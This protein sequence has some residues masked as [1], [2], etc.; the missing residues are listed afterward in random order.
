MSFRAL[1]Q[2]T[3]TLAPGPG[4]DR[5]VDGKSCL[6]ADLLPRGAP[7]APKGRKIVRNA[8]TNLEERGLST[9]F[10]ALDLFTWTDAGGRETQSPLALLPV[11]G[12]EKDAAGR[13]LTLE[14]TDDLRINPILLQALTQDHGIAD[15]FPDG[16]DSGTERLARLRALADRLATSI[17]RAKRTEAA[18]LDNFSFQKMAMVAELRAHGSD[19]A[20]H[21]LIAA[22]ARDPGAEA[23]MSR[24]EL[25]VDPRTFDDRDPDDEL[26]VLDADS[27][28]LRVIE[29]AVR[30]RSGVIFGAPGTGKSQT[31]ANLVAAMVGSG[32]RVLFVAEKRAALEVVKRRLTSAGLDHLVLDLHG[33]DVSRRKLA[34][35][36]ESALEVVRSTPPVDAKAVH[37]RFVESRHTL[38]GRM[39]RLH[40]RRAEVDHSV[41]DILGTLLRADVVPRTRWRG[42]ELRALDSD[43]AKRARQLLEH[44]VSYSEIVGATS[45]SRWMRATAVHGETILRT[46]DALENV[47]RNTAPRLQVQ[48]ERLRTLGFAGRCLDDM[49]LALETERSLAKAISTWNRRLLEIDLDVAERSLAPA[50]GGFLRR[51]LAFLFSSAFRAALR[52]VRAARVTA[53]VAR[54]ALESVRA[55]RPLISRW[56]SMIP[57]ADPFDAASECSVLEATT[58]EATKELGAIARVLPERFG[59]LDPRE[60][61]DLAN[62]YLNEEAVARRLVE[63]RR[64]RACLDELAVGRLVD[65]LSRE[66]VH[67]SGWSSAFRLAWLR[68]ALDDVLTREPDLVNDGHLSLDEV[69]LEFRRS[70]EARLKLASARVRRAH[71]FRYADVCN[72]VP[73]QHRTLER[74]ARKRARHL[75]F[76]TLL[77]QAGTAVT[78][79]CPCVMASPLSVSQLLPPNPEL[80]DLV[81]FD[82]ASQVMPAD[83]VCALLRAKCAVVAGDPKQLP[84]TTFFASSEEVEDSAFEGFESLIDALLPLLPAWKLEWHY[85]SRDER[86]I[87]FSNHHIYANG[88]VTFPGARQDAPVSFEE[89]AFEPREGIEDSGPD[90]VKTVV[91]RVIEHAKK[92]PELSLGVITMGIKHAERVLFALDRALEAESGLDEFFDPGR[93][94]R[95]FVKNLEQVQGDER[96]VVFLSVGYSKGVDGRLR[97]NFGPLTQKGGARRLN[98]AIT[99]ARHEMKVF[100]SFSHRDVDPSRT[101]NE[102]IGLLARFLEYAES[103]GR[104]L[105]GPGGATAPLNAFEEDVRL[106]LETSG[107]SVVPQ[108]GV[109][110]YRIDFAVQ[111]PEQPGRFVLAIE[112]DGA[113]YHAAAT[114]RDR[115]RLRQRQLEALGWRVHRIWSSDWFRDRPAELARTLAVIENAIATAQYAPPPR[116]SSIPAPPKPAERSRGPRPPQPT[117]FSS[118]EQLPGAVLIGYVEWVRS[119]G[120]VRFDEDVIEEVAKELGFKRLGTRIRARIAAALDEVKTRETRDV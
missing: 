110:K 15:S 62:G 49:S 98:V 53:T 77:E 72:S 34:Q 46:L 68:S 5:L 103:G 48:L 19:F 63:G 79:L 41:Y 97:Y 59:A 95:F 25:P 45:T 106:A 13:K 112:C 99:R 58:V 81:I 37:E 14:A 100:A 30:G 119:D 21:D 61:A 115:D 67:A 24:R 20:A 11:E 73:D 114:A 7:D 94:E 28:Q 50:R 104:I 52:Q 64:I 82:E 12:I 10:V 36:L 84:P 4:L 89:A 117:S 78:S 17:P 90:E 102:G 65:E 8:R 108:L 69:A 91:R 86:L 116:R 6:L 44:A 105:G 33:A 76:R 88:L 31:I 56:S 42:D 9:L 38:V 27:S 87:A 107:A 47:R 55:I 71:A 70:D 29:E 57:R 93:S 54:E 118:I 109:S 111:H 3:L 66:G 43:A 39:R 80:F 101:K 113:S 51:L 18:F 26:L 23:S 2:G 74:E 40:E 96:D 35:Q 83:A 1:K 16:E 32:R 120:L 22:L 85:R 60:L 75:P 92:T